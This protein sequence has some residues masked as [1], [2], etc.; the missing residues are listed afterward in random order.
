MNRE[1]Y[2]W[3]KTLLD[4]AIP[5]GVL[6]ITIGIG[7]GLR[8]FLFRFLRAHAARTA[9]KIDDI[10]ITSLRVPIIFWFIILGLDLAS[11]TVPFSDAILK[12]IDKA[13]LVLWITSLTMATASFAIN[14]IKEY[15]HRFATRLAATGVIQTTVG[16]SIYVLGA[17]FILDLLGVSITPII[18]ALGIG[19]LAVALALQDTLSN[20]IAGFHITMSG[21]V[22]VGDYI[23]LD[24]GAEGYVQ[25]VGWRSTTIRQL[26]NN[27]VIVPN[28]KLSQS[29]ITNYHLPIPQLS[30]LIPFSVSYDT[31]VDFV[32][33]VV[34]EEA[35]AAA[36][37]IP[38][39]LTDPE[40]FVRFIPGF[41]ESALQFTLICQVREF[42]DQYAVQH[43]IRKRILKRFRK[44][45]IR[46]PFPTQLI[47]LSDARPP[48][49]DSMQGAR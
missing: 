16:I 22:R 24:S 34:V 40:P 11:K 5:A 9:T 43:E 3:G 7:L 6:L 30:V 44:E 42:V 26:S 28:L 36:E 20:L 49:G 27:L 41:G 15:A 37:V 38:G 48:V 17:L 35:K 47:Y 25:D 19:G 13:M 31:D 32:E 14:V 8:Y 23:K 10:L 18:T 33:K 21:T 46:I 12:A 29:I 1:I 4:Y 39:L 45:G 2:D